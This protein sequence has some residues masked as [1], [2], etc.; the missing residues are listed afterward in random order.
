MAPGDGPGFAP[1]TFLP[2][3]ARAWDAEGTSHS[4]AAEA[5]VLKLALQ[6]C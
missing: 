1:E 6:T 2:S 3:N 4:Q 5:S